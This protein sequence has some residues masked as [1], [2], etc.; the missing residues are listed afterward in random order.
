MKKTLITLIILF[1]FNLVQ[2]QNYK[3]GA[4]FASNFFV[5]MTG[6]IKVNDSLVTISTFDKNNKETTNTYTFVKTANRIT[7]FTDG[8]TTYSIYISSESGK[9]KGFEYDTLITWKI[10]ATNYIMYYAKKED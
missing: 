1:T 5:K 8:V 3:Y 4:A 10:D 7:Y 2:S 9:K 6:N